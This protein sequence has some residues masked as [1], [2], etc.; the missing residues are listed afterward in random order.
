[1]EYIAY[2]S[3]EDSHWLAEFPDAPGCQ[4]FADSSEELRRMAE[5]ALTG[6]LETHLLEGLT[7]AKPRL[8]HP[9]V[10]GNEVWLIPIPFSRTS[11][12]LI[13]A[14]LVPASPRF[15]VPEGLVLHPLHRLNIPRNSR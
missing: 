1:M 9:A 14:Y 7:P 8:D 15:A 3:R 10:P 13:R 2:V 12:F 4:T 11:P 6:W 5:E